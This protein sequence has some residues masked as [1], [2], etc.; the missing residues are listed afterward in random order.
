[1]AVNDDIYSRIVLSRAGLIQR[2]RATAQRIRSIFRDMERELKSYLLGLPEE[3]LSSYLAQRRLATLQ[4]LQGYFNGSRDRG[5]V[6]IRDKMIEVANREQRDLL[7]MFDRELPREVQALGF[8]FT[9]IPEDALLAILD[10]PVLGDFTQTLTGYHNKFTRD[11][12]S[13]LD[14]QIGASIAFGE[15]PLQL[16][17]RIRDLSFRQ[18]AALTAFSRT[19]LQTAGARAQQ[20]LYQRNADIIKKKVFTATF[21]INTCPICAGYDGRAFPLDGGPVIPVHVKCR[22]TYTPQTKSLKEL[23]ID[24][25]LVDLEPGTKASM[26]GSIPET[27]KLSTFLRRKSNDPVWGPRLAKRWGVTRTKNFAKGIF[28]L[29]DLAIRRPYGSEKVRSLVKTRELIRRRRKKRVS[30]Q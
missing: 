22:C 16:N 9:A 8:N 26:D 18:G 24:V 25:D 11:V 6:E 27:M 30:S 17:K 1:M 10:Q 28:S 21:D 12:A 19:A 20:M 14:R 4:E 5:F 13:Q 3:D 15:G 29:D 23:G 7:F 2:E